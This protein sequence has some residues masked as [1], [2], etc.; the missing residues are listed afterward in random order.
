MG[1]GQGNNL[2]N[3]LETAPSLHHEQG[4]SAPLA[5]RILLG[6]WGK[7]SRLR[8]V[9]HDGSGEGEGEKFCPL[10]LE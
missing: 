4:I 7:T 2:A 6:K 10:A 1:L 8:D 9:M 5:E 3:V